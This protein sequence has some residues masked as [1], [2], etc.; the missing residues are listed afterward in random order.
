[1]SLEGCCCLH[2]DD[3]GLLGLL[4]KRKVCRAERLFFADGGWGSAWVEEVLSKRSDPF[5]C[6]GTGVT[7][8]LHVF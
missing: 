3:R 1:M 4:S 8:R 7:A 6:R 2:Q 5:I